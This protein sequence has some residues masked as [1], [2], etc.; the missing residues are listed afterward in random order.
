MTILNTSEKNSI[1]ADSSGCVRIPE[2]IRK[3]VPYQSGKPI[4]ELALEKG[5]ERI[6]KLASNDNPLG[7]SPLSLQA[8]T[9]SLSEAYRYVDPGAYE[10]TTAL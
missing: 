6:V 10:L 5:F 9:E 8:V 1:R 7:C 4:A 3:L 2:H